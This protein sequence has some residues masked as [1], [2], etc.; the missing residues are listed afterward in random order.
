[1]DSV[2]ALENKDYVKF[3]GVLIDTLLTWKQH[4]DY[5]SSKNSKIVGP[6]TRLR[7][8]VPFKRLNLSIT[9][10]SVYV[11]RYNHLGPSICNKISVLKHLH[12]TSGKTPFRD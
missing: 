5:N 4:I 10:I 1:M 2:T 11:L 8:H 3:L 9:L 7:H 6:I 12:G